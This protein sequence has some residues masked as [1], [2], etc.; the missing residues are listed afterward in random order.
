MQGMVAKVKPFSSAKVCAAELAQ[1]TMV[2]SCLQAEKAKES[3]D[4]TVCGI[5]AYARF[6]HINVR[7]F[8]VVKDEGKFTYVSFAPAN[9]YILIEVILSGNVMLVREQDSKANLSIVVTVSGRTTVCSV[10]LLLN[11]PVPIVVTVYPSISLGMVKFAALPVYPVI[12]AH[13]SVTV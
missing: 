11:A 3:I 1:P 7:L 8:K 12:V 9:A 13:P 5:R 6:G 10:L 2:R 4:V